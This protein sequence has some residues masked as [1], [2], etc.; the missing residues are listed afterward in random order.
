M[1]DYDAIFLE[2]ARITVEQDKPDLRDVYYPDPDELAQEKRYNE[3]DV[4]AVLDDWKG[5][6]ADFITYLKDRADSDWER[7]AKHPKRGDFTLHDQLFLTTW[8][9]MNHMEQITR[10]LAEKK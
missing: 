5:I 2:R 10:I 9:D 3:Q 7:P 6:R 1:R 4:Q 8:H